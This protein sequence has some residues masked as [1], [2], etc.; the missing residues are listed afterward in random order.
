M[1]RRTASEMK[2]ITSQVVELLRE[3]SEKED[4]VVSLSANKV[5][6]LVGADTITI[7]RIFKE[8]GLHFDGW[9]WTRKV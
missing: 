8:V 5:A 9:Y 6:K 3:E 1:G 2:A 4:R 7:I